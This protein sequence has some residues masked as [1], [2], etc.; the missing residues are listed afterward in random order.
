MTEKYAQ[1][2]AIRA[3]KAETELK[4]QEAGQTTLR[5][6]LKEMKVVCGMNRVK[7]VTLVK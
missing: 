1:S 2:V 4:G 5:D 6:Q 3:I 7:V